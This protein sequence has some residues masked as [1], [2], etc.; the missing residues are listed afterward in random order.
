MVRTFALMAAMTAFVGVIGLMLGG[1]MGLIIALLIAFG[2]NFFS[3]WNSDK[4]VLRMHGARPVDAR[5]A[6]ELWAM[7]ESMA[8]RAGMPMPALY[9]VRDEQPVGICFC[10]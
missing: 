4:V 8:Q 9:I 2:M 10:W 1:E 7:T 6:P 5:S 3:Y